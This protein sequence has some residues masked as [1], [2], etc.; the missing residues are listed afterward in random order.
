M[1]TN[2]I[3]LIAVVVVVALVLIAAIVWVARNKRT[4]HRRVEAASI[5]DRAVEQSHVVGQSEAFADEAAA[6]ARVA[7]AEADA[8]AAHAVGLRHQAQARQSDA[9]VAR[10]EVNQ[11]FERANK[12]DPDTEVGD[13][14]GG[15]AAH[16]EKSE[17]GSV[18]VQTQPVVRA[19]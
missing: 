18:G 10:D 8:K 3:V 14:P 11:E 4:A 5:R 2:N 1:T 19:R 13:T 9:V 16:R 7:Q 6:K 12:I 17:E 15:E